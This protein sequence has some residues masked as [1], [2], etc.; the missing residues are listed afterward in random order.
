MFV[1][2][3]ST[4]DKRPSETRRLLRRVAGVRAGRC[5]KGGGGVHARS[6]GLDTGPPAR[7]ARHTHH[8]PGTTAAQITINGS[9]GQRV[10]CDV[11]CAHATKQYTS[12]AGDAGSGR[13]GGLVWSAPSLWPHRLKV[14]EGLRHGSAKKLYPWSYLS[15]C[16]Y[17]QMGS[18]HAVIRSHRVWYAPGIDPLITRLRLSYPTAGP[19][20]P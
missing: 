20:I 12:M 15:P 8:I 14:S 1:P 6:M 19:T 4:P 17:R 13:G 5:T 7:G 16:D 10:S 3:P 11:N 18:A 9:R 2:Q